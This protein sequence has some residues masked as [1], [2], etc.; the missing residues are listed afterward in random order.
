MWATAC[1]RLLV[2]LSLAHWEHGWAD[3]YGCAEDDVAPDG[4]AGA[5]D[6]EDARP[7]VAADTDLRGAAGAGGGAGALRRRRRRLH[8]LDSSSLRAPSPSPLLRGRPVRDLARGRAN[9]RWRLDPV[10]GT[11]PARCAPQ[12][13]IS[14][15]A[16]SL[17]Q[18]A[19]ELGP[20]RE[21]PSSPFLALRIGR[22]TR[23]RAVRRT[24]RGG[25][26][27]TGALSRRRH[28]FRAN[29]RAASGSGGLGVGMRPD[30]RANN[31]RT[32]RVR[33]SRFLSNARWPVFQSVY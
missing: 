17:T 15:A 24:R 13:R 5:S 16:A 9:P 20:T 11:A 28:P 25:D 19:L 2:G 33:T 10:P 23:A 1:A 12:P 8:R 3:K 6:D 21:A 27:T 18:Q 32:E 31:V 4:G 7:T 14:V 30:L 29:G 26:S 22:R